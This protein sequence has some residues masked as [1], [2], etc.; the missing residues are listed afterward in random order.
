MF[1][2]NTVE[3]IKRLEKI[4]G[5]KKSIIEADIVSMKDAIEESLI[6]IKFTPD[7]IKNRVHQDLISLNVNN[8]EALGLLFLSY[9]SLLRNNI[10]YQSLWPIITDELSKYER[11]GNTHFLT[12]YFIGHQDPRPNDFLKKCI[13]EAC[14]RFELRHA[15]NHKEDQQYLR[16]TIFL[17]FGLLNQ[18]SHLNDWISGYMNQITLQELLNDEGENYSKTF[19][20]GWRVLKRYRDNLINTTQAYS[21]LRQNIWFKDLN[22]D[23]MLKA[24]KRKSGKKFLT[25]DKIEN[26]FNFKISGED[27]YALNLSGREYKIYIDDDYIGLLLYDDESK[28]LKIDRDIILKDPENYIAYLEIKNEESEIVYKEDIVLFDFQE[29]ILIFDELGNFYRNLH[30]KLNSNRTYSL[31]IDADLDTNIDSEAINYVG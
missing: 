11:L 3:I 29:G 16:N 21:Q 15:F 10:T 27:F 18:F 1:P 2:T 8:E 24:S 20:Y 14:E 31:L 13:Y 25:E 7:T 6:S 28:S 17:Q 30:S 4:D 26:I 23:D 9:A 5:L 22:I 12:Q 19:N